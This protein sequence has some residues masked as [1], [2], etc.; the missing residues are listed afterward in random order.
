MLVIGSK[1]REIRLYVIPCSR[2]SL[3]DRIELV[4]GDGR[5]AASVRLKISSR[6]S[7]GI[8]KRLAILRRS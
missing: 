6:I 2:V 7:W 5:V 3:R 8:V 1:E 4:D